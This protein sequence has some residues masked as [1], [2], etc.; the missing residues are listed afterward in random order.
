ML[1][2]AMCRAAGIPSRVVVGLVYVTK[3][4]GFGYHM[5]YEVYIN[6]RWIALD[7]SW[8]QTTVDAAHIKLSETSLEGVSPFDAFVPVMKVAGKL[9]IEPLELR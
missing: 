3:H 4:Q 2:A 8:D 1:G 7:P 5:W 6:G 9:E